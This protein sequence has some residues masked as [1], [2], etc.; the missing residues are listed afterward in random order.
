M[1]GSPN[2]SQPKNFDV[3]DQVPPSRCPN[4]GAGLPAP[5]FASD[6]HVSCDYC[7]SVIHF[8]VPPKPAPASAPAP[9][10]APVSAWP[11]QVPN[12]LP[13]YTPPVDTGGPPLVL[14]IILLSV[15]FLWAFPVGIIIGF[16]YLFNSRPGYQAFGKQVL[17]VVALNFFLSCVLFGVF[18]ALGSASG[19]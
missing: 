15:S 19:T 6:H 7:G 16:V 1:R 14:R 4:C 5:T 8:G 11:E 3:A 9:T 18:G 10:P 12:P 2:R 13:D 17:I